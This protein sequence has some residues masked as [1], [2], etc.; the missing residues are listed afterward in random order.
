MSKSNFNNILNDFEKLNTKKPSVKPID[1]PVINQTSEDV[2]NAL[3]SEK[4]AATMNGE[5]WVGV[6]NTRI[7][8][9][10]VRNGFFE[11]DWNDLFITELRSYGYGSD[12]DTPEYIVELWFKELCYNV[13]NEDYQGEDISAGSLDIN[14]LMKHN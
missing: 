3:M 2:H 8:K 14:H 10:D 1:K 6:L 4:N 7:N 11:L 9:G 13:I 5:P 12:G